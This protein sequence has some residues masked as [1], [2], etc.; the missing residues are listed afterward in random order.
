M[1]QVV[2]VRAQHQVRLVYG[3]IPGR[4]Q[5]AQHVVPGRLRAVELRFD[6]GRQRQVETGDVGIGGVQRRLDLHEG[7]VGTFE[8][9][10]RHSAVHRGRHD[11]RVGHRRVERERHQVAG[12]GRARARDHDQSGGA[13]LARGQRLVAQAGIARQRGAQ[14]AFGVLGKVAQHQDDL[15]RHVQRGVAVVAETVGFRHRQPVAGEHQRT[16]DRLVLGER[17]RARQ[18]PAAVG[19]RQR[20]AVFMGERDG[21][22][23]V[24]DARRVGERLAVAVYAWQ[25]LGADRPELSD[26]VVGGLADA[27]RAGHAP[28]ERVVGKVLDDRPLTLRNRRRRFSTRAGNRGQRQGGQQVSRC[29]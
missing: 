8:D 7:P 5:V 15:V 2:V 11:A 26:D 4:R 13:P 3:R 29:H 9:G 25:R 12:I 23:N 28:F 10:L 16:L 22:A 1:A 20:R 27:R 21:R 24:G 14:V 17:Q 6:G 19:V 18:V